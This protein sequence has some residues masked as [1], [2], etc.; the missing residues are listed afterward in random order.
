MI[1]PTETESKQSIDEF[2]EAMLAIAEEVKTN[3]EMVKKAPHTTAISRLDETS[4]VKN[5]DLRFE[6]LFEKNSA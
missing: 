5:L 2:I 1:E 3:P 4:A 6:P